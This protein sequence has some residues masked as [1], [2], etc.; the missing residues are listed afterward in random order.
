MTAHTGPSD[1]HT[2]G[3]DNDVD[4]GVDDGVDDD[5]RLPCGRLLSRV[6]DDRKRQ[7]AGTADPHPR[8]CPHCRRAVSG[9]DELGS[10]VAELRRDETADT[11]AYDTAPLAERVMDLVRLELRPG[12]PLPLGE[13]AEDLWIMEAVAARTLRAAAESVSG[14]R[15]G[16]CR[17]F[18][19]SCAL[20]A[21]TGR[22]PVE[23]RLDVHAPP[24]VPLPELAERIRG[25][26]REAADLRL[27]MDV[28]AVDI[29]ISDLT[30]TTADSAAESAAGGAPTCTTGSQ[31][32]RTR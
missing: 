17:L 13:P 30:D 6:W 9:L 2:D 18:P 23:V 21:G 10:A 14:V 27:G 7:R 1:A 16:S 8:T 12:R 15:A 25:R 29:R 24:G 4:D 3:V 31:E 20:P 11:S 5:E 26:V 32:G 28:A 19:R 22:G